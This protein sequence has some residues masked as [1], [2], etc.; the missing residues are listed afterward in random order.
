MKDEDFF[1]RGTENLDRE[2]NLARTR[3]NN[4]DSFPQTLPYFINFIKER[5]LNGGQIRIHAR[6]TYPKWEWTIFEG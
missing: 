2:I 3:A 4:G 5:K 1:I 6:K